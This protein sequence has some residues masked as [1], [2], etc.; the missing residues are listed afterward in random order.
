MLL[1]ALVCLAPTSSTQNAGSREPCR[2][3]G[4]GSSNLSNGEKEQGT[5]LQWNYVECMLISQKSGAKLT[6]DISRALEAAEVDNN[7]LVAVSVTFTCPSSIELDFINVQNTANKN[8]LLVLLFQ[9]TCKVWARNLVAFTKSTDFR[10]MR[11]IGKNTTWS[12]VYTLT[13]L[14]H[15]NESFVRDFRD[16]TI[17]TAHN[18]LPEN[19]PGM[20][21][22]TRN[23]WPNMAEIYFE[24]TPIKE[25]PEQW[26][27]TM[28]RLQ[29]LSLVKCNLTEPPEF[30]WNNSTLKLASELRRTD[31]S[32][33]VFPVELQS[34]LY[35][36]GLYLD[37]NNIE[38]L[39]SHEFRGFLHVLSLRENGLKAIGPSCFRNLEGIQTIDLFKNNLSSLPQNLFQGLTSLL[40]IILGFN[41]LTVIEKNIFKGLNKVKRIALNHNNLDS[42]PN[43]LFSSLSTLEWLHLSA[44]NIANIDD[45]PF[46]KDSALQELHLFKNKLSSFPPWVFSLT[47][48]KLIDLSSNHLTFEDLDKALKATPTPLNDPLKSAKQPIILNLSHNNITKLLDSHGLDRIKQDEK[49]SPGQ[50]RQAKYIY[51]WKAYVIILRGNPLAC[52]CIMSSVAQ[53]IKKLLQQYPLIRSWFE[54]WRCYWPLELRNKSILEIREDQWLRRET[55]L[56]DRNCPTECTC[57]QRCSSGSIVVDCEKKKLTELPSLLPQGLIELNLMNNDIRDIPAYPYLVNVTVLKLTNNKVERLKASIVKKL[58]RV[59][60]LLID[61]NKLT[62]LPREI[63]PLNITTL[64]LEQNLF[65]CDCTTKWLK[66]WLVKNKPRIRNIGK[67]FCNSE[68]ALGKVIYSLPDDEFTCAT[69]T[70]R[71][72]GETVPEGTIAACTLGGL[73]ALILFVGIVLYKYHIQVKVFMYTHF[74]WHPFDR[75]D[76]SD[77]N[78]I[79]D[80]FISFSGSDFA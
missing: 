53:E 35:V 28:P 75:I 6:F 22:D 7:T 56:E 79:Y 45:N 41:N 26:K 55:E 72:T 16:I 44:N 33:Q 73:L 34:N 31:D 67:V 40:N 54:T 74:N 65:K 66:H 62:T 50:P 51:L 60:I 68:H 76:D 19:I 39:T 14:T 37:Y 8:I 59:E 52:D 20:F 42:I 13:N 71:N 11:L 61:A 64:A 77:P 63:E 21:T 32:E 1:T 18:S 49:I 12:S 4:K 9:G 47:K 43:G 15:G 2:L 57:R 69:I 58:K 23:V 27:I 5:V 25:I 78:K 80:A 29:R 17:I 10:T 46:P 48:I 3:K 30:P 36:R 70:E 24:D 38:D